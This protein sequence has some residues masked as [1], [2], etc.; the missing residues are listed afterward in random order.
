MNIARL[1]A[2][3]IS[4]AAVSAPLAVS[5]PSPLPAPLPAPA[6]VVSGGIGLVVGFGVNEIDGQFSV[7]ALETPWFMIGHWSYV[8]SGGLEFGGTLSDIYVDG[9]SA[10]LGG[11][12]TYSDGPPV[13]F[14][15]LMK[16]NDN[17]GIFSSTPDNQ[18]H[19][20]FRPPG[21]GTQG[22]PEDPAARATIDTVP[23]LDFISGN[24]LVSD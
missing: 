18:S 20:L 23:T 13:G 11:V 22:G 17:G 8:N 21:T 7:F 16:I 4:L 15:V 24:M 1:L 5:T 10:Y 6:P 9:D 2:A 3:S 14:E 12:V 19:F